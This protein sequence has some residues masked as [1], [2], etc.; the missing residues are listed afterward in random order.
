MIGNNNSTVGSGRQSSYSKGDT[1]KVINYGEVVVVNDPQGLGRIKVRIKGP[2][3]QGGDDGILDN[4]LGWCFPLMPKMFSI[5]PKLHES[6]IVMNFSRDRQ[7]VDRLYMGPIISQP[8]KLNF[9][10]HYGTALAGFTFG[11]LGPDVDIDN[12]PELKGVFPNRNDVS[13]QGRYNTDITQKDNEIVIRAGKFENSTPSDENKYG[14]KFNRT[15]Q[16]FIQIKNDVQFY[17]L[18]GLSAEK[19][20]VTNVVANKINLITHSGGYPRFNVTNQT[21]LIS[22]EELFKI[23]SPETAGGAHRLPFGDVL[24]E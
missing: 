8:Q 3:G 4:D 14:F 20:T 19:G 2:V 22:D 5:Q 17:N 1:Y 6:V 13:I 10:N 24:L 11:R 18:S 7:H 21:D 12:I 16:A 9:D 23:L 15:T